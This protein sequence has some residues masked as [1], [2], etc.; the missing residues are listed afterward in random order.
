MTVVLPGPGADDQ[1]LI[2]ASASATRAR[3]LADAGLDCPTVPAAVDE[4]EVKAAL[5][6]E[7]ATAYQAAETLAELKAVRVSRDHPRALVIGADQM[8]DC[9]GDWF[10]KAADRDAARATLQALSRRTHRLVSGVCIVEEGR[11]IWHHTDHA[12][13]TM[14]PLSAPFIDAYLDAEGDRVLGSVGAYRLEGLGAQ[15]FAR[16]QGDYFTVLGLPLLPLLDFLRGRGVLA[17]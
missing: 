6:G 9:D 1:A 3:L 11:R 14:R 4:G 2:L 5:K 17:A 16:V 15:L 8:L 10:D 13:L 7:G 12:T